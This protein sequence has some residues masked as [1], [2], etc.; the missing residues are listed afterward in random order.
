MRVDQS[1]LEH[2]WVLQG[3]GGEERVGEDGHGVDGRTV[4]ET[5]V[6]ARFVG[7]SPRV[8]GAELSNSM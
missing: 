1:D 8:L 7:Q 5:T 6:V 2:S 4:I 3:G